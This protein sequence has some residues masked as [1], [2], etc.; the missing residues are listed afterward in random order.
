MLASPPVFKSAFQDLNRLREIATVVAGHGFGAYLERTRLGDLVGR[1]PAEAEPTG[2]AARPGEGQPD[3]RTAV[4]FRRLLLDLGPT[5]IKLGQLLSSRP[6]MLPVHWI[7][8]LSELQDACPP[9]PLAEVRREIERGLSHPVGELFASLEAEPLASASIAQVHRARTHQGE[10]V[11]VK[12]QRPRIRDRIEAD[13]GLLYYLARLLEAVVEETGVYTPTDI[14]EE[15]DKAIHEELDFANEARNAR[16][17]ARASEGLE[18]LVIPRVHGDLSSGTVL[19][20]DYVAGVK[21]SEVSAASGY[22]LEA[23]AR[24]IIEAAFRQLFEVGVFH[25]DP[26]PGNILVLPGNRIALIDFGLVGRLTRPMQ[27]A[28]VTLIMAVALRDPDTV[29]R[30]LYRVGVPE[31]H[32]PIAVLRGD[33][34]GILERYL[35]LKLD[36]IRTTTLLQDLLDIA[37][38]HKIKVPKEY[39][40]LSK[41]SIAIEGLIR[42]LH[43][44]LDVLE[45]GLPYA[46]E[47]LL[48]RFNPSDVSGTLMKSLLKFQGLAEDLP[49]QLSQILADLEG[50]KLRVRVQSEEIDRLAHNV[51]SLT[52]TLFLGVLASGLT[53]GGLGLIAAEMRSAGGLPVL[54]LAAL[55]LAGALFGGALTVWLLGGRS[56]KISLRRFLS[57]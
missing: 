42:R 36:Q 17:M 8:E 46:K 33:I 43:P 12:V 50:G 4:R 19:T 9:L 54:G 13:L 44:K 2:E 24:T 14:V 55:L 21:V 26:H 27:E 6:D 57:R 31:A 53:V 40:L 30:L 51:R 20:M 29:A 39:A 1:V 16:D 3:R 48:Q 18:A 52:L 56:R 47:L 37:V 25:G 22:D 15:F 23:V 28:L 49:A 41:A 11:V 35:G 10:D 32:A 38:R 5:F 7:E 34:A 45:V